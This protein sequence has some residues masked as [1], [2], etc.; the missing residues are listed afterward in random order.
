MALL[1]ASRVF[2]GSSFDEAFEKHRQG[3]HGGLAD[4]GESFRRFYT[5]PQIGMI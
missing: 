5:Y 3:F 4:T 2:F 1:H